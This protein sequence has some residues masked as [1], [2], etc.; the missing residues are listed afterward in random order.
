MSTKYRNAVELALNISP[1]QDAVLRHLAADGLPRS[2][3]PIAD[4]LGRRIQDVRR[5]C[6]A[7]AGYGYIAEY[8]DGWVV[9]DE[10]RAALRT[11]EIDA[12]RR[13]G[14]DIGRW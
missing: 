1:S 6:V 11:R 7:L 5:T 13:Q 4:E 8:A 14:Y 3:A 12:R 9:V 10:G 2:L